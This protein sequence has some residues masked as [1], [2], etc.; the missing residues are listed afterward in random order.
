MVPENVAII[1]TRFCPAF[2]PEAATS[3]DIESWRLG[4]ISQLQKAFEAI[5]ATRRDD[6]SVDK[7]ASTLMTHRDEIFAAIK[8]ARIS[9]SD[10]IKTRIHGDFHLGQVLLAGD[11]AHIIDFEGEPAR[12]MN[13]RRVKSS[14]LRDVAGLLRSIAYAAKFG[15]KGRSAERA[16]DEAFVAQR[17]DSVQK[18]AEE[19]FLE[20]Y[21]SSA[22]RRPEPPRPDAI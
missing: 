1:E 6:A 8:A 20:G 17:R 19:C 18:E 2:A 21:A 14:P 3:A 9:D 7:L 10:P 4:T 15:M 22:P 12:E 13:E 11:D 5:A 16:S